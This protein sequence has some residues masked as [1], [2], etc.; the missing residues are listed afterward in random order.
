MGEAPWGKEKCDADIRRVTPTQGPSLQPHQLFTMDRLSD[1]SWMDVAAYF[2][3]ALY[4]FIWSVGLI[5]WNA[6]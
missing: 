5:G 2:T 6:A 4:I 1:V 3:I